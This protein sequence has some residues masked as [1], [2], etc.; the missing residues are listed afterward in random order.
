MQSEHALLSD[1]A[2][3]LLSNLTKV[4]SISLK[5][6]T[7]RI[8]FSSLPKPRAETSA[9]VP[10]ANVDSDNDDI[11]ALDLLLEVFLRGEGKKYNPNANYDFL[12]SVFANVSTVSLEV[13]S[14]MIP[15]LIG[16]T[17]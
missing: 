16:T 10:L 15:R 13:I 1:L 7:L 2:S 17:A 12:A 6:L 9:A 5:L 3:M 14:A 11:E 8:P 4:D